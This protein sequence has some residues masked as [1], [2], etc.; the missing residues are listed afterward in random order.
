MQN[1]YDS[2]QL[3]QLMGKFSLLPAASVQVDAQ[4]ESQSR[5]AAVGVTLTSSVAIQPGSYPA[6]APFTSGR[7]AFRWVCL[8]DPASALHP[9]PLS[10]A[11][12]N[13]RIRPTVPSYSSR[14]KVLT[15]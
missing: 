6:S 3:T 11:L 9:L 8:P 1:A 10:H 12:T 5:F 15:V 4:D 7:P 14:R 13:W 2:H